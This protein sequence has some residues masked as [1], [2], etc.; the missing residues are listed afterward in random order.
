MYGFFF[1][2]L[3]SQHQLSLPLSSSTVQKVGSIAGLV[4]ATLQSLARFN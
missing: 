4:P 1:F 2:F 3:K